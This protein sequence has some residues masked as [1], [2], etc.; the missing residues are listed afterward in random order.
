MAVKPEIFKVGKL[1]QEAR[2]LALEYRHATGKPLPGISAELA[3]YD[4]I[5]LLSLKP[6]ENTPGIDALGSSGPL[7]GKKIQVKGRAIFDE[8]K[9]GQRIG[10][11]KLE[12]S[13]DYLV[14]VLMDENLQASQIFGLDRER[15]EE[16]N[17][18]SKRAKRGAMS[19]AKFKIIGELLWDREEGLRSGA[20]T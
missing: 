11:L 10:Q 5:R 20:T 2:R 1:M 6:C 12:Q 15:I 18:S 8:S 3:Q 7:L 16:E 19:V 13:W 17:T 4:A 14:L 9:S